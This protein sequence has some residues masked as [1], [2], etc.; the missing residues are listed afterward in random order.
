MTDKEKK[1]CEKNPNECHCAFRCLGG[2][3]CDEAEKRIKTLQAKLDIA[4]KALKYI[5]NNCP[6]CFNKNDCPFFNKNCDCESEG[7]CSAISSAL[8]LAKIKEI[9]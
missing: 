6:S 2:E 3:F 5:N 1:C 7:I 8:A 9:K 4:V